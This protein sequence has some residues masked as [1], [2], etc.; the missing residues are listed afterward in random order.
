MR[1]PRAAWSRLSKAALA[2]EVVS[3]RANDHPAVIPNP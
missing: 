1:V 2:E 3:I